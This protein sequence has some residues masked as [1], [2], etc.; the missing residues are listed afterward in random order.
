MSEGIAE[1]RFKYHGYERERS[2]SECFYAQL[3]GIKN[4]N[5]VYIIPLHF[6]KRQRP[7]NLK[8]SLAGSSENLNCFPIPLRMGHRH[9]IEEQTQN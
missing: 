3:G 5:V 6:E 1:Y 4:G 7:R 8:E 2:G 9:C